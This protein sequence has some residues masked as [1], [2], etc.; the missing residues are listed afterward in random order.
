MRER[1]GV[2]VLVVM[3]EGVE[4][5]EDLH[6][7]G[8]GIVDHLGEVLE[9]VA[10]RLPRTVCRGTDIDRIRARLYGRYSYAFVARR[11]EEAKR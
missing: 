11:S 4:R 5:D 6:A 2:G 8:M 3:E 7:V 1:D 10:C 9:G